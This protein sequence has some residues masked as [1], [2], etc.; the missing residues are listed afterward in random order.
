MSGRSLRYVSRKLNTVLIYLVISMQFSHIVPEGF[1]HA[2][3][4]QFC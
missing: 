2:A 3:T 4:V 1:A